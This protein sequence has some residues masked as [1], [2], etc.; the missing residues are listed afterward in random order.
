LSFGHAPA[1]IAIRALPACNK[2]SAC[3]RPALLDLDAPRR[4][5]ARAPS[6]NDRQN[7]L[8]NRIRTVHTSSLPTSIANAS[9]SLVHHGGKAKNCMLAMTD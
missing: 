4:L 5:G 6:Q 3:E 2:P 8:E 1:A 9:H 7:F